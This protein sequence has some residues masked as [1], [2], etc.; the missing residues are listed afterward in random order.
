MTS[1]TTTT[2]SYIRGVNLG[3]WL[4][5]ERYIV[6]YQFSVTDCHIRGDFC[7]F[8]GQASAPT[9]DHPDYTLCDH[10]ICQPVRIENAFGHM[11]YPVDEKTLANAFLKAADE[12]NATSISKQREIAEQWFN[13]HFDNFIKYEDVQMIQ[14]A[15][16]THLRVPLPH[17]ILGDV[18][19]GESWIVGKR[20]DAFLRLSHWARELNLQVW[21]DI[22]TAP[23]SQNGFGTLLVYKQTLFPLSS[24][25]QNMTIL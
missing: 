2:T 16:I 9:T 18:Q 19:E 11:D 22:H 15:G 7:W 23:G 3:G 14:A 8:P 1:A 17:W 5:L 25:N 12:T 13:F 21:P 24:P 4:V 6:P 10:D 20:W